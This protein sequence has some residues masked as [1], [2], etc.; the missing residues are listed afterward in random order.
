MLITMFKDPHRDKANISGQLLQIW[1][2]PERRNAEAVERAEY[3]VKYP[4]D[5]RILGEGLEDQLQV[6]IFPQIGKLRIYSPNVLK[7]GNR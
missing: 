1:V 2:Q 6:Y 4:E 7:K 3:A 5:I